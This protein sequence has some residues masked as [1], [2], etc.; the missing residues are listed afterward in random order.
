MPLWLVGKQPIRT[1]CLGQWLRRARGDRRVVRRPMLIVSH[2]RLAAQPRGLE[3]CPSSCQ[4]VWQRWA[5][6]PACRED[7]C[8]GMI[9]VLDPPPAAVVDGGGGDH[10]MAG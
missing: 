9:D 3:R 7:S 2:Q 8:H 6:T 4:P 5:G 10:A 1:A